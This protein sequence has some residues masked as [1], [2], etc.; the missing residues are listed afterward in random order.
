[1]SIKFRIM[2]QPVRIEKISKQLAPIFS[3]KN[4]KRAIVFGALARGSETR[5]SDLD[6]LII[7]DTNKRF[8]DRFDTFNEIYNI[9]ND[10]AVD[11]LIYT[12]EELA[13]ISHRPFIKTI[14]KEGRVIYEH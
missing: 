5:K 13:K 3:K 10:R 2:T 12:P 1:M 9:I 11:M 14:L 7:M 8:F 6:L 4:V